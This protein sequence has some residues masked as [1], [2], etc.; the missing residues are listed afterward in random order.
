MKMLRPRYSRRRSVESE[1]LEQ[2]GPERE[3]SEDGQIHD[4]EGEG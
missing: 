1:L 4:D 2:L 3:H